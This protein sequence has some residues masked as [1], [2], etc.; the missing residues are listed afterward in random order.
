LAPYGEFRQDRVEGLL[1]GN[2]LFRVKYRQFDGGVDAGV[3]LGNAGEL[4][5]GPAW[6]STKLYE[7]VGF[8]LPG[9][10]TRIR[11]PARMPVLRSIGQPNLCRKLIYRR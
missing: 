3:Q 10:Q 11:M 4:R 6:G 9:G 5:L 2:T 8:A 7:M 1:D